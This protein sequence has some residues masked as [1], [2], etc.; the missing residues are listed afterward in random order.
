MKKHFQGE[1]NGMFF[2]ITFSLNGV[3]IY[4]LFYHSV[5]KPCP[6]SKTWQF[7]CEISLCM[8]KEVNTEATQRNINVL[9]F[10]LQTLKELK[11]QH[12]REINDLVSKLEKDKEES[13]SSLKTSLIAERQVRYYFQLL[14]TQF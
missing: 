8:F 6:N 13:C 4:I 1:I 3:L 11:E 5:E 9:L 2:F 14:P 10:Y 12:Q 7:V